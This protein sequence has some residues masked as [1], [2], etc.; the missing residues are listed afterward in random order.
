MEQGVRWRFDTSSRESS[1]SIA[2][3]QSQAAQ[4]SFQPTGS[5]VYD[6]RLESILD[7]RA[8]GW[9]H[10]RALP[11]DRVTLALIVDGETIAETVADLER[12]GLAQAGIGDGRHGFVVELPP[13]LRDSQTDA[14]TLRLP[15]GQTL[16]RAADFSVTASASAPDWQP[17]RPAPEPAARSGLRLRPCHQ[18]HLPRRTLSGGFSDGRGPETIVLA[19]HEQVTPAAAVELAIQPGVGDPAAERDRRRPAAAAYRAGPLLVSRLPEAIVDGRDFVLCPTEH[20]YLLDSVRSPDALTR[21]GYTLAADW[22]LERSAGPILQRDERIVVLGA[23][24][25]GNYSHWLVE[26]LARVLLFAPLDDGSRRYLTPPLTDWQRETLELVGLDAARILELD[27]PQLLRFPE[28]IAV[29][30]AITS[31]A[32]LIP[33]AV[34]ALAGLAEAHAPRV[35][36]RRRRRIYSSRAQANMRHVSNEA[37][38]V[39]LLER[40]GF[41]VLYPETLTVREQIECFAEA[42][43]VLAVHGSG[44]TNIVFCDPGTQVIELQPEAL[45]YG[46]VAFV[47]NLAAIRGQPF[48]QVVCPLTPGMEDVAHGHRDL[49]VD[50]DRLDQL[51]RRVLAD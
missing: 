41:E 21:S 31:L 8:F 13:W 18:I 22:V 30:R 49:T 35:G 17:D 36:H 26:S 27:C 20:Q 24:S 37:E 45:N 16:A 33:R 25:H 48:V 23:Q 5:P 47:W 40:H 6:G 34:A 2:G 43:A 29:S 12:P 4:T 7:G 9:A 50:T 32:S 14:I 44:L 3:V 10:N 15:D 11:S 28:A 39:E 38:L 1:R 42:E 51:L 46:G 19:D